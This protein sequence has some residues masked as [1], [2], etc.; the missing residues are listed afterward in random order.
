MLSQH[1]LICY[2]YLTAVACSGHDAWLAWFPAIG[3]KCAHEE[4]SANGWPGLF[5]KSSEKSILSKKI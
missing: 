1:F 5:L 2:A 3:K 4:N